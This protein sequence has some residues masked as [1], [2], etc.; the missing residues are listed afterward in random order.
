MTQE[1]IAT[2]LIILA[3]KVGYLKGKFD[4]CKEAIKEHNRNIKNIKK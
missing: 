4:V 1:I 3:Y 2:I